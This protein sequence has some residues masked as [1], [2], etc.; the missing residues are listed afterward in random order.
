MKNCSHSYRVIFFRPLE[1]FTSRHRDIEEPLAMSSGAH[2]AAVADSEDALT[3]E[4]VR[5]FRSLI[6]VARTL[7]GDGGEHRRKSI[8]QLCES[9]GPG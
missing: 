1:F 5:L 8:L 9:P 7:Q 2:L 6:R 4:D 3:P